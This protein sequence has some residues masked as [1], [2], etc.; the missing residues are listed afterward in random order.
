MAKT[1]GKFV[2]VVRGTGDY[3]NGHF[4]DANNLAGRLVNDLRNNGHEVE[5]A[6]FEHERGQDA[7]NVGRTAVPASP[8]PSPRKPPKP[9]I[10]DVVNRSTL[11][12][13]PPANPDATLD[14]VNAASLVEVSAEVVADGD[15][16]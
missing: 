15:S 11:V 1:R 8:P 2:I 10:D 16:Q 3:H 14:A 12:E 5:S 13:V 6:L 9:T 7:M 4:A